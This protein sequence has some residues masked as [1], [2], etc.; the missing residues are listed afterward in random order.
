MEK[1]RLGDACEILNGFAF[2]SE[3]YVDSGIRVIRIA[4]VQKGYIEDNTPAFYPLDSVGLDKYMLEEGDL[5]ISLTGNVGRVAILEKEFLPAALNQR[6]ACLRLKTSRLTK[7]YLFHILNDNLFE[8]QCIQ[9]SKGVAQ[10]N[11]ST[12]WLKNYEILLYSKEK[13]DVITEILDKTYNVISCRQQELQKLDDLIRAR[14]VELFGD[15]EHNTKRWSIAKLSSLCNVGSS[16]RI[17]Q[18]ELTETGI[19]FLRISDLNEKIDGKNNTPQL[20]IPNGKYDELQTKGLV[21]SVGDIL[22]TARGTLGRCYIIKPSDTF[23]FQDGMISWLSDINESITSLYLSYL[24][25]TTGVQKQ[26]ANLQAGST[27]AYL[28]IAMLKNLDIMIP[29]KTLQKQFAYFV[30]QVNKSKFSKEDK[31]SSHNYSRVFVTRRRF[32]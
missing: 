20:F 12:E 17:Y 6:V 16:K 29:P 4:N 21:P 5:L 15:S 1:I 30:N 7:G 32:L 26:I 9:S 25:S 18:S 14:F 23:Y 27:V 10:K 31:I 19:P 13:Q 11:M 22:V 2:K 8:Q 28:S 24:F 3:N